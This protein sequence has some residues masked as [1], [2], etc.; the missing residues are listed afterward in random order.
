[1]S[2]KLLC[3]IL[4][5]YFF[6]KK[7]S[8]VFFRSH[9]TEKPANP[10]ELFGN[11]QCSRNVTAPRSRIKIEVGSIAPQLNWR[12]NHPKNKKKADFEKGYLTTINTSSVILWASR[13]Q[14]K[15]FDRNREQHLALFSGIYSQYARIEA[16]GF[17][18]DKP[19]NYPTLSLFLSC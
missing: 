16:R 13:T 17:L 2:N 19:K 8:V 11:N 3:R 14:G 12:T 18:V 9:A 5:W 10:I 1:M 15:E 7:F 6:H 4:K